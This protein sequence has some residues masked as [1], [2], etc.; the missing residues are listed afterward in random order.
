M[1]TNLVAQTRDC[2]TCGRTDLP[3]T[4]ENFHRSNVRGWGGFD[5]RCNVCERERKNWQGKLRRYGVTRE[6]YETMLEGQGGVCVVCRGEQI[7]GWSFDIDHDH[8]TGRIRGLLCR[9][10]NVTLGNVGDDPERLRR[11]ADYLEGEY[12]AS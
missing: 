5:H 3:L 4:G 9:L 10:C 2:T 7:R 6:M 11:L 8:A 12:T 1:N